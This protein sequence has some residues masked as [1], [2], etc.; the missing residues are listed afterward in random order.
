MKGDRELYRHFLRRP[1]GTILEL[2]DALDRHGLE[3]YSEVKETYSNAE[4]SPGEEVFQEKTGKTL[5]DEILEQGESEIEASMVRVWIV[6]L[7]TFSLIHQIVNQTDSIQAIRL[8]Y[9]H[10][11]RN[12]RE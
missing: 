4:Q 11:K 12:F 10:E 8:E 7:K 5:L 1:D 9:T 3:D 2:F 6:T